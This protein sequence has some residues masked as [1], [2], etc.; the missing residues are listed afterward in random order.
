MDELGEGVGRGHAVAEFVAQHPRRRGGGR[1]ADHGV[2]VRGPCVGE[3]AQGDCLAAAGRRERELHPRAGRRELPH[4]LRLV[5]AEPDAVR[6]GFEQRQVDGLALDDAEILARRL[7]QD[8]S[9]GI[10]DRDRRV[11]AGSGDLVH[12]RAVRAPQLRRLVDHRRH[13]EQNRVRWR[14]SA[15]GHRVDEKVR[16]GGKAATRPLRLGAHVMLLPGRPGRL[17]GLDHVLGEDVDVDRRRRRGCVA[18]DPAHERVD[19]LCSAEDLARLGAPGAALLGLRA[20]FVLRLPGGQRRLLSQLLPLDDRRRAAVLVLEP[21]RQHREFG[22]DVAA[23][24]RPAPQQ[25]LVDSD[26]L[27]DLPLAVGGVAAVGEPH[28]DPLGEQRLQPGVVVLGGGDLVPVQRPSVQRQ[29]ST[30]DGADLVRDRDVGVQIRIARAGVAVRERRRDQ[31][32]GVDLGDAVGAAAGVGGVLLQPADRVPHRLVV[33]RG[34]RL[35]QL[36]WRDRPQRRHALD[37]RERQVVAGHRHWRRSRDP[38]QVAGELAGIQW[39][40]AV[41][42]AEPLVRQLGA[43]PRPLRRRDRRVRPLATRRVEL[44]VARGERGLELARLEQVVRVTQ[45]RRPIQR[46]AANPFALQS[47]FDDVSVRVPSFAEQG[48]HLLLGHHAGHDD[49]P[50]RSRPTRPARYPAIRRATRPSARSKHRANRG[51]DGCRPPPRPGAS[52]TCTRRRPTAC[53]DSSRRAR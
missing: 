49:V 41:F 4:H 28:P 1:Q 18:D 12:R 2:P 31:P 24:R 21:A 40:A 50:A 33:A 8:A 47:P 30:I 44:A 36:A 51:R 34:D 14:Q 3:G 17:H 6:D 45:L 53:A 46:A 38:G 10:Q 48:G 7:P 23:P 27:A 39:V 42:G 19:R 25:L 13:G 26:D 52:G 11:A 20:R 9:L 37:R 43:D 16:H 5:G 35:G 15:V 29:P 32:S 22:L